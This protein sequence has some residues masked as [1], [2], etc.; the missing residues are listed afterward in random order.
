VLNHGQPLITITGNAV[1]D[2]KLIVRPMQIF[3]KLR[4]EAE[5]SERRLFASAV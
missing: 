4:Q 2:G 1:V 3:N 5:M